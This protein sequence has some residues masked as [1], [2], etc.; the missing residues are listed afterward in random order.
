[1]EASHQ[2]SVRGVPRRSR[3]LFRAVLGATAGVLLI[4]GFALAGPPPVIWSQANPGGLAASVG[5]VAWA[6]S[7]ALVATGLSDRWVRIRNATNGQQVST[8]FQ[9]IRSR[10]VVRLQFSSD[11]QFLAVSNSAGPSQYRIYQVA[12][13]TFLGLLQGSV[14]SKSIVHFTA[15]AQLATAPGGA[16]QLST[17]K[18]SDLPVFVSSGSGYDVVVTRFQLSPDGTQETAVANGAVTV[19]RVSDGLVLRT[20]TGKSVAFSPDSA[21]LAA[22]TSSPNQTRLY[23]TTD[24]GLIRTIPAANAADSIQLGW[25]PAGNLVGSGY[26]PFVKFDGTWDQKGIVRFW[27]GPTGALLTSYDQGLSIGSRPGLPSAA[28]ARDWLSGCTTGRRLRR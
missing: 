22:W 28:P 24:F 18:L 17:W 3:T 14:D 1:M 12:T 9:P 23:R 4:A 13:G 7:G 8:I 6:P 25:T 19:R 16:G 26:L 20:F 10:G 15:D 5:A 2:S 27:S 21:T 11:S